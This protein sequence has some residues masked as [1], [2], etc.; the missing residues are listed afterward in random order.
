MYSIP[1]IQNSKASKGSNHPLGCF[2]LAIF[3]ED[4]FPYN[5]FKK[6]T[7]QFA[8]WHGRYFAMSFELFNP[9]QK[10]G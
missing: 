7:R 3:G 6:V 2:M 9:L 4:L 1:L 8:A 5:Y 10:N